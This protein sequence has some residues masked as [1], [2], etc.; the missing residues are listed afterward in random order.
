M[1]N[2]STILTHPLLISVRMTDILEVD[3]DYRKGCVMMVDLL[4]MHFDIRKG[5][6]MRLDIRSTHFDLWKG[7]VRMVDILEMRSAAFP[8]VKT[9][10]PNI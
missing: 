5:C 2:T 8:V 6:V 10:A 4:G 9:H 3:F 1:Y 7:C